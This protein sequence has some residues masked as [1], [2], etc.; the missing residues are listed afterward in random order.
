MRDMDI[1]YA[2]DGE[3]EWWGFYSQGEGLIY[4]DGVE[5]VFTLYSEVK[6]ELTTSYWCYKDPQKFIL[7]REFLE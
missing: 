2:S 7:P 1:G 4:F 6:E 3:R 5:S